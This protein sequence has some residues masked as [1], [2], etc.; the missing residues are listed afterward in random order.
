[1]CFTYKNHKGQ[2]R[3]P[4]RNKQSHFPH[5]LSRLEN[6]IE[7]TVHIRILLARIHISKK[8]Q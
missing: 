8:Y 7:E 6:H 1:M 3:P 5:P 4:Q 2:P